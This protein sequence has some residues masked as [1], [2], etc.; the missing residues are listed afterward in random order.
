LVYHNFGADQ[1]SLLLKKKSERE[2]TGLTK[3]NIKERNNDLILHFVPSIKMSKTT[4]DLL[5]TWEKERVKRSKTIREG[6]KTSTSKA[7]RHRLMGN[8][9]YNA[10][11]P[12]ER[13][14]PLLHPKS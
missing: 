14:T 5:M 7:L 1:F 2:T 11:G 13:E 12:Q 10:L 3:K 4:L 6:D 8:K 9:G